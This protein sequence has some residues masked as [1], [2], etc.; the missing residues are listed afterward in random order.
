MVKRIM[1]LKQW[2][3]S[4]GLTQKDIAAEMDCESAMTICY[5]EKRGIKNTDIIEKLRKLSKNKINDFT[6]SE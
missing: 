2:R 4:N 1:N 6:G 5:W 3:K